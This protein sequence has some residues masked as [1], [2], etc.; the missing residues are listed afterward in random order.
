[1][2]SATFAPLAAS[3]QAGAVAPLA[4]ETPIGGP[5]WSFVVPALLLAVAAFGTFML[6][7]HFARRE[8]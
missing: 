1:M 2:I 6:Y 5:L 4:A 3:V 8:E 7:R